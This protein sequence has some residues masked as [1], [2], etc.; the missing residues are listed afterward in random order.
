M[1]ISVNNHGNIQLLEKPQVRQHWRRNKRATVDLSE[2]PFVVDRQLED[3]RQLMQ[4]NRNPLADVP[5]LG[6]DKLRSERHMHARM[7]KAPTSNVCTKLVSKIVRQE[8]GVNSYVLLNKKGI[9][10]QIS[11]PIDVD[12]VP[13]L[14]PYRKESMVS[15]VMMSFGT[16]IPYIRCHRT[17]AVIRA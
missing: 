13:F 15:P 14:E 5:V 8:S 6:I 11:M 17:Y 7:M 10:K 16:L 4:R 1:L 9:D 3:Q 2:S 12:T